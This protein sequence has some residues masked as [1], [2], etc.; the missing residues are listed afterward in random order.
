MQIRSFHSKACI[1]AADVACAGPLSE[2]YAVSERRACRFFAQTTL[3]LFLFAL[4]E[5]AERTTLT[6]LSEDN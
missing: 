2:T 1:S 3:K 6:K 4:T 5:L